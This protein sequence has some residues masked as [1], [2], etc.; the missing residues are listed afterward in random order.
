M[1]C[2][3]NFYIYHPQKNLYDIGNAYVKILNEKHMLYNL[4]KV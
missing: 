2:Y 4:Y 1:V 3:A